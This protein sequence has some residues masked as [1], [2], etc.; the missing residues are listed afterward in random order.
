MKVLGNVGKKLK[1]AGYKVG[2]KVSKRSPEIL[3][4]AGAITFVGTVIVACRQTLK[5]EDILDTHERR[6]DE[7]KNCQELAAEGK[8]EYTEAEAKKDK[9]ITFAQTGFEFAKVY[10][11]AVLLGA[12]S[13][14]CFGC[15]FN[16][17]R[18]RNLALTAAYTALDGA[19]KKYRE[20][21]CEQLG[22][23]SDKYFRYGYKKV[24]KAVVGK[25][26]PDT[27][28]MEAVKV[29]DIDT[30]PWDEEDKN[31][32]SDKTLSDAVFVFAPE[33]SKY[34]SV[35]ELHNDMTIS[36]VRNVAQINFDTKGYMFLNEIL[37]E[38]GLKE[39][40][41]GQLVGW[42]KGK[43][44]PYIK[45]K[46]NKVYRKASEDRNRNPLGLEYECIYEL[47]FNTCG[48]MWDRI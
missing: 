24:K 34:F 19:F 15:S 4:V 43:G 11:P 48:I 2:M 1:G 33:T 28:E 17:M 37:R 45:F 8:S 40:P 35:D 18:K 26:N 30:V 41:Y 21:V 20:R 36:S 13:I 32:P 39:V 7:I 38:L 5:C 25:V 10:A 46:V 6:I 16:I 9:A 29:N 23:E 14:T 47:E 42:V 31:E 3:M 44:D 22:E 12:V 27:G